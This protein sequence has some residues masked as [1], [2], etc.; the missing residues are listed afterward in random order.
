M[1]KYA[2][3]NSYPDGVDA[4][5]DFV[6]T[7]IPTLLDTAAERDGEAPFIDF[8]GRRFTFEFMR[9]LAN[10]FAKGLQDLDIKPG[11]RVAI[12]LPNVPQYVPALF[13]TLKTG[14]TVVNLS[15]LLS[16]RE[17]VYQIEDSGAEILVT[18]DLNMLYHHVPELLAKTGL[19]KVVMCRMQQALPFVKGSLFAMF[20]GKDIARYPIDD[21]HVQFVDVADNDGDYAVPEIDP[22]TSVALLQYTGGTTGTPKGAMLSHA[23]IMASE[24]MYAAWRGQFL[25]DPDHKSRVLLV[26]PLFH[27]FGLSAVLLGAINHGYEVILHPRPDID[28]ILDDIERKK[29]DLLPGVPTLWTAIASH[30]KADKTDFSS[31]RY[32]ASGGAPLSPEIRERFQNVTGAELY[33]GYGLTETAPAATGQIKQGPYRDGSC[34]IPLPGTVIEIRSLEDSTT[35][36]ETGEIGEVCIK[37]PQLLI[38]YW[39]RPEETKAAIRDGWFHTGDTGYLDEDG[40]LFIVDRKKDMIISSGFNVY[41]RQIEDEIYAHPA[42]EEVTVIGIP[43]DY[44][45]EV[46][47]AFIKLKAGRTLT[48]DELLAFLSDRL[49]KYALPAEMDIR[50]ELPKTPVG[51]LSK[52]EL[53]AEEAAKRK[54]SPARAG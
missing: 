3:I 5:L 31:L 8:Y 43:D 32:C 25:D 52:K 27:I 35:T 48:F 30:P 19:R 46:P 4:T 28:R 15:P 6:P 9:N 16:T 40:F 53:V 36:L 23:S 26:L 24:A 51:K 21:R 34:G 2:W 44:K 50:D 29:P 18:L 7:P 41:P 49:A 11:D 37:G 14:A 54:H 33:E 22:T 13:G 42:V 12:L 10:R 38:G 45:G 39:N 17:L 47:K 20:K 1:A